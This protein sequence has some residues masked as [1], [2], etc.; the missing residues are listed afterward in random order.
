GVISLYSLHFLLTFFRIGLWNV[1]TLLSLLSNWKFDNIFL[2]AGCPSLSS[3][4]VISTHGDHAPCMLVH[5]RVCMVNV[6]SARCLSNAYMASF[7]TMHSLYMNKEPMHDPTRLNS[8][9]FSDY[10]RILIYSK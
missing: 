6:W 5:V 1:Q 9:N 8:Y 10:I 2:D 3:V 4:H 7:Y